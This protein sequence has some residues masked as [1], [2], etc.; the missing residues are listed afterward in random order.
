MRG[1]ET[2]VSKGIPPIPSSFIAEILP[3]HKAALSQAVSGQSLSSPRNNPNL[4]PTPLR[5]FVMS[6]RDD[7]V[8]LCNSQRCHDLVNGQGGSI[9]ATNDDYLVAEPPKLETESGISKDN[10][11]DTSPYGLLQ[12]D[13]KE[14]RILFLEP[15]K[16]DDPVSCRLLT[17]SLAGPYPPYET[18][19]YVWEGEPGFNEIILDGHPHEVTKNLFFALRRLRL[20]TDIDRIL[21]V[22]ALCI[23]QSSNSEKSHQ[24]GLM[25]EIYSSCKQVYI[26]LGEYQDNERGIL[27]TRTIGE[28]GVPS[29]NEKPN[30]DETDFDP[31]YKTLQIL[32]WLARDEVHWKDLS[33]GHRQE[34]FQLFG[35]ISKSSWWTRLWVVQEAVLPPEAVIVY[36]WISIPWDLF[37]KVGSKSLNHFEGCCYETWRSLLSS[38]KDTFYKIRGHMSYLTHFHERDTKADNFHQLLWIFRTRK[39][40]DPRDKIYGLLGLCGDPTDDLRPDYSLDTQEVYQRAT[41]FCLKTGNL[42]ILYGQRKHSGSMPSWVCDLRPPAHGTEAW[43]AEHSRLSWRCNNR[44]KSSL[45]EEARIELLG[46]SQISITGV[47]VDRVMEVGSCLEHHLTYEDTYL[48]YREWYKAISTT[49]CGYLN[50]KTTQSCNWLYVWHHIL[51]ADIYSREI[52][53]INTF[54]VFMGWWSLVENAQTNQIAENFELSKLDE[55]IKI[56]TGCRAIFVTEKG[57]VGLGAPEVGDEIWVPLGSKLPLVFRP[58]SDSSN[59]L[60]I[61]DCFVHGIMHGEAMADLETMKKTV[62]LS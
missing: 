37:M 34:F 60:L 10:I 9:Y 14:F 39:A 17:F 22:D 29:F 4:A 11:I 13:C 49:F 62:V 40:S 15:G 23:N 50:N 59:H 53:K 56:A 8:S 1:S 18:L 26:W 25:G 42:G 2:H 24:V 47:F 54:E 41:L 51:T 7:D 20:L 32:Y 3:L 46:Q 33:K 5:Y 61:G 52:P 45:H 30:F 35:L 28:V 19:S 6:A 55:L 27:D 36:G 31:A 12:K 43:E 48:L 38:E 44:Y 58:D 16:W 57:Y 21:W